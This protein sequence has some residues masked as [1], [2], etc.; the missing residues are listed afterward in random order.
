MVFLKLQPYSQK[1]VSRRVCQ[2]LAAKFYGPYKVIERIGKTA[3]KL[4]LPPEARIHVVFHISQLKLALGPQEQCSLL[5]PGC[6]TVD[7]EVIEPE[8]VLEKRY[9]STGDL[10]LLVQWQGKSALENSWLLYE[11]FKTRFPSYQLEGK[12]DFVGRSIDRFKKS[13]YRRK[14][15]KEAVEEEE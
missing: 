4:L 14:K 2:K 11:E 12:L 7:D 13:Y 3:Y 15:G 5:P 9:N 8:D 6:V 10:E 1:T